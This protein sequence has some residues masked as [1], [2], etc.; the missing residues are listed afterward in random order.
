MLIGYYALLIYAVA[1]F[2]TLSVLGWMILKIGTLLGD[3]PVSR[4]RAK[5]A[6]VT[7]ATGYLAIGAGGVVLGGAAAVFAASELAAVIGMLGFVVLC[8]GLGFSNA[9]AT[10]RAVTVLPEP[11]TADLDVAAAS[12]ET[13]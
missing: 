6:S 11:A 7:V 3:C 10:L 12:V 5:A 8:L 2:G 1:A 13:A 9:I 4:A